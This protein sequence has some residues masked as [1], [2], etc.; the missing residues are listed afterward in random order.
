MAIQVPQNP[1]DGD[2]F[3]DIDAGDAPL[4]NG[5]VYVYDADCW[6]VESAER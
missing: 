6:G 3:P 5:R 1:S 4:E 2:L